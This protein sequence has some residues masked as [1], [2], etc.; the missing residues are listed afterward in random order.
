MKASTYDR[1]PGGAPEQGNDEGGELLRAAALQRSQ[2]SRE[3]F[4]GVHGGLN[5]G[6]RQNEPGCARQDQSAWVTGFGDYF[7][8][9]LEG[10]RAGRAGVSLASAVFAALANVLAVSTKRASADR[11]TRLS[12]RRSTAITITIS[13]LSSTR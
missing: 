1:T 11:Y 8:P 7:F 6:A 5:R 13:A 12:S 10:R 9:R 2:G 3:L 4:F